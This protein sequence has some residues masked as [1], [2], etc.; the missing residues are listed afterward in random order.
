MTDRE[1]IVEELVVVLRNIE[2]SSTAKAAPV[3]PQGPVSKV[4]AREWIRYQQAREFDRSWTQVAA[5][6]IALR[7]MLNRSKP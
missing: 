3:A 5:A 4:T 1:A 7:L 6:E 2:V